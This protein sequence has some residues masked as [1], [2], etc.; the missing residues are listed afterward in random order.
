MSSV[1]AKS[2]T[3]WIAELFR[4]SARALEDRKIGIEI[5]RIAMWP[6][7]T[8]FSYSDKAHP[9]A[10]TLLKNLSKKHIWPIITNTEGNPLGLTSTHGKVSL[11]PGSQVELSTDPLKDIFQ[12]QKEVDAFEKKVTSITDEWGL[13]WLT[14]G[15]DPIHAVKEIELIPSERYGIMTEYFE[16]RSRLGT[17]MMRRTASV[18][19]NLDYTSE[20]EAIEMLRASLLASPI[21]YA[22]FGNS[23]FIDGKPSGYVSYRHQ[24]W[25]ETDPNRTGMF[26]E[27]FAKD[28]SFEK[29]AEYLWNEPLMFVQDKKKQYVAADGQTLYDIEAGKLEGVVLDDTNQWNAIRQLFTDSRLKPGYVE[30]RSVDNLS[31]ADRYACTAFWVGLMYDETARK[32]CFELLGQYDDKQRRELSLAIA[33][34]GLLA[35]SSIPVLEICKKL[36]E[37]SKASLVNRGLGEEAFLKPLETIIDSRMNPGQKALKL[38]NGDLSKTLTDNRF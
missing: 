4:S 29:L 7:K 36:F 16:K 28:F 37:A 5:E 27:A 9:G 33:K 17:S 32:L 11:E 24:I 35:K 22:L 3:A 21:S 30:I 26:Q 8:S 25:L 12:V 2:H 20:K 13:L 14:L 18:Q 38:W 10:S 15:S 6:D 34:D 31:P 1:K 19:I 23:P